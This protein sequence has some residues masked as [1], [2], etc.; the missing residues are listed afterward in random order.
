MEGSD[1]GSGDGRNDHRHQIRSKAK[2]VLQTKVL[3]ESVVSFSGVTT[4]RMNAATPK[5]SHRKL[6]Q[7]K[8]SV[9]YVW[10]PIKIHAQASKEV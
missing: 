10:V 1:R 3:L 4:I 6:V 9:D 8:I 7:G 5:N 2:N